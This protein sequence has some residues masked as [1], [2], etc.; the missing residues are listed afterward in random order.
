[1]KV[2]HIL[3][4]AN[5]SQDGFIAVLLGLFSYAGQLPQSC[6]GRISHSGRLQ[7]TPSLGPLHA[8]PDHSQLSGCIQIPELPEAANIVSFSGNSCLLG[9]LPS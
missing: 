2:L 6:P 4:K 8:Q 3:N 7:C 9:K 1:M 5:S